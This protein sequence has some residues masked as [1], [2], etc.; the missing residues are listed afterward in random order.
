MSTGSKFLIDFAFEPSSRYCHSC[1]VGRQFAVSQGITDSTCAFLRNKRDVFGAAVYRNVATGNSD[2][3]KSD[4]KH[5]WARGFSG[6]PAANP[7]YCYEWALSGPSRI[8]IANLWFDEM[9]KVDGNYETHLDLSER[10]RSANVRAVRVGRRR[11]MK[12]ILRHAYNDELPVRVI[13]LKGKR[14]AERK[15]QV[16]ARLLDPKSWS[17]VRFNGATGRVVLRRGTWTSLYADQFSINRDPPPDGDGSKSV[18]TVTRRSRDGKVR[19]WVLRFAQGECEYCG[20]KGF[21]LADGR[22]Y[23]ET[24]HVVPLSENGRDS[25]DNVIA[26]CANDHR[27]AHLGTDKEILAKE[28]LEKIGKRHL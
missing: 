18:G 4:G 7:K 8:V 16:I 3:K 15:S 24:H 25:H 11:R 28:F 9:R 26:L 10:P 19:D 13:V 21:R 5:G 20:G 2:R 17:I 27:R 6:A 14:V 1:Y 23:L 22:L 12:E